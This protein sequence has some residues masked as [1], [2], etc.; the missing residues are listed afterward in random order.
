MQRRKKKLKIKFIY[1]IIN[2]IIISTRLL[3]TRFII[4][5]WNEWQIHHIYEKYNFFTIAMQESSQINNNHVTKKTTF[6]FN[7]IWWKL[8]K[9][10]LR[11]MRN[12]HNNVI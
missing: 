2:T 6:K 7:E 9:K 11:M 1:M 3:L 8:F 10:D 12:Q 5:Y 4:N